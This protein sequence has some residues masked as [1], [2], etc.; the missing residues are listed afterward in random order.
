[1]N[2]I[3]LEKKTN[4]FALAWL[5]NYIKIAVIVAFIVSCFKKKYA[6]AKQIIKL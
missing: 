3:N 1:M 4:D 6:N 5:Y 2:N